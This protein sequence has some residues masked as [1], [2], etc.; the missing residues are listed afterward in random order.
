MC[1]STLHDVHTKAEPADNTFHKTHLWLGVVLYSGNSTTLKAQFKP[2]VI[3]IASSR[4]TRINDPWVPSCTSLQRP[5]WEDLHVRN[6][7]PHYII[8]P[9]KTE[10]SAS[11]TAA[12][13]LNSRGPPCTIPELRKQRAHC[14]LGQ[15]ERSRYILE[16]SFLVSVLK[17]ILAHG[18]KSK[19][20]SGNTD[21]ILSFYPYQL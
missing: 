21:P 17:S 19:G 6:H 15:R 5:T 10:S 12:G 11:N 8:F 7:I 20:I 1:E 4:P 2:R 18:S 3:Y 13:E 9:H 16:S 14:G